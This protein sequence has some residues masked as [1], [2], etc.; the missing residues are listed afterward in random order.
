[1]KSTLLIAV[2]TTAAFIGNAQLFKKTS[3][4]ADEEKPYKKF[5]SANV[6]E[7]INGVGFLD[8]GKMT[9]TNSDGSVLSNNTPD[10]R[11]VP[12]SSLFFHI[13]EQA[14]FQLNNTFGF[15]TGIGMRNVGMI[16]EIQDTLTFTLKQRAY[17][18][19]IP[20]AIKIGNMTKRAYLALGGEMEFFFHYKQKSWIGGR[21]NKI[22]FSQWFSDRMEMFNASL[23]AEV[24]FGKGNFIK[25]RYYPGN[26]LR[27]TQSI[28]LKEGDKNYTATFTP[29]QSNM[30]NITV[31]KV[32][33][34]KERKRKPGK[35]EPR[36][37][38]YL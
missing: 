34:Q 30:F 22:K 5:Y 33:M 17:S 19:G 38:S 18:I 12:R 3:S 13:A 24:N 25:L 8:P 31:G 28:G 15:Y 9:I 10:V 2:F 23:F 37:T 7:V 4:H 21:S 20:A 29:S 26:W 6:S 11:M 35:A 32:M 36:N 1:M 16:N 14:H 27:G